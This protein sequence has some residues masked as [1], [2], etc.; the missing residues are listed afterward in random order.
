[1]TV[2]PKVVIITLYLSKVQILPN[3]TKVLLLS[4]YTTLGTILCLSSLDWLSGKVV[5]MPALRLEDC[6]FKSHHGLLL[7]HTK[8]DQ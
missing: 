6:W 1:M 5:R 8:D 4:Y 7:G 3:N 2:V